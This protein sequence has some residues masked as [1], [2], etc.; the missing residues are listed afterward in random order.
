[1]RH[2]YRNIVPFLVF[3]AAGCGDCR[4]ETPQDPWDLGESLDRGHRDASVP[5][6][7]TD[8]SPSGDVGVDI[9]MEGDAG[10]SGTARLQFIHAVAREELR[11][12]RVVVGG[13]E[14]TGLDYLHSTD[15]LEV[16]AA[17]EL[18]V[19]LEGTGG[20]RQVFEERPV[21]EPGR[22]YVAVLLGYPE[23][24]SPLAESIYRPYNRL[25][26]IEGV[27]E[28]GLPLSKKL[29]LVQGSADLPPSTSFYADGLEPSPPGWQQDPSGGYGAMQQ[30]YVR[31]PPGGQIFYMRF[32]ERSDSEGLAS[33]IPASLAGRSAVIVSSGTTYAS[34]VNLPF[35]FTWRLFP[36]EASDGH[37]ARATDIQVIRTSSQ[38]ATFQIGER[39]FGAGLGR[40]EGGEF[41]AAVPGEPVSVILD[42]GG[43][44]Q[45]FT[46][47][48]LRS[49]A[50]ARK[51]IVAIVDGDS[52]SPELVADEYPL[53]EPEPEFGEGGIHFLHAVPGVGPLTLEV[54]TQS[55]TL[56][57]NAFSDRTFI[58]K[59]AQ[60]LEVVVTDDGGASETFELDLIGKRQLGIVA[61]SE[62]PAH[63]FDLVLVSDEGEERRLARRP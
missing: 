16:T 12:A 42:L 32:I 63:S 45:S 55:Y 4:S 39:T 36:P 27:T 20:A 35:P 41:R 61:P 49:L 47:L 59:N 48:E 51:Y 57:R 9:D 8:L 52:G 14:L 56:D 18:S 1:M 38:S 3:L 11:S 43:G 40:W 25:V 58:K 6:T 13:N 53:P 29:F 15:L 7:G 60:T 37:F 10:V 30:D 2:L 19:V 24:P 28:D 17:R 62:D 21:L 26:L 5:D 34:D 50:V 44:Q 31:A 46:S 33:T 54:G 22:D 23:D